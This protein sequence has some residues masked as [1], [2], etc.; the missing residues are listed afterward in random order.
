VYSVSG[1]EVNS[2]NDVVAAVEL[3]ALPAYNAAFILHQIIKQ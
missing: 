1:D 3:E 2:N